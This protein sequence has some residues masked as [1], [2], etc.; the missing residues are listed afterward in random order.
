MDPYLP[1]TMAAERR[2]DL[3]AEAARAP[4]EPQY[5]LLRRLTAGR[6]ST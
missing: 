4:R 5:S 2:R 6:S 3:I 1:E